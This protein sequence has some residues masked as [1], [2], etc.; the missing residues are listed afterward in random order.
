MALKPN[1][2]AI[3]QGYVD[4]CNAVLTRGGS[5]TSGAPIGD[6]SKSI[7]AIPHDQTLTYHT[8]VGTKKQVT[9]P[10]SVEKYALVDKVG[11]MTYKSYNLVTYPYFDDAIPKTV[12]E[13]IT[14]SGLT[15]TL[16][17]D[18]S[19][20]INGTCNEWY[21]LLFVPQDVV[22]SNGIAI[23]LGSNLP[24]GSQITYE[25]LMDA[26]NDIWDT[27]YL[28]TNGQYLYKGSLTTYGYGIYIE[29]DTIFNN[30]TLR[31][32]IAD[33]TSILP[34]SDYFVG[35]RATKVTD[36]ESDGANYFDKSKV[37][38]ATVTDTGFSFTNTTNESHPY[39]IGVLKDLAPDLKV[40]DVVTFYS[41]V[42]N[43]QKTSYA[44]GFLYIT[45]ASK[46]WYGG[47]FITITEA[48]L[49]GKVY[50]YGKL[51]EV[52][53][54]KNLIITKSVGATYKPYVGKLDTLTMPEYV[55]NIDGYGDGVS[56]EFYNYV[57]F[58]RKKIVVRSYRK[59]CDGTENWGAFST[60][61]EGYYRVLLPTP[62]IPSPVSTPSDK[63]SPIICNHYETLTGN[64]VY[65][66]NRGCLA[67]SSYIGFY[68]PNYNTSDIS[69]WKAHLADLYA[70]GNPLMVVYALAEPIEV[71]ISAYLTDEG[72]IVEGG[73]T[74]TAV[75]EYSQDLPT[76]ITYLINTTGGG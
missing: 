48:H 6:L 61:T 43:P 25:A 41:T 4:A 3:K 19:F 74:I 10:Q 68:D 56:E 51:N 42:I 22:I 75:N 70:Q 53:E 17:A 29:P 20:T 28:G 21:T 12:G 69:L 14:T 26:E 1:A 30:V 65:T 54:Y 44:N 16:N 57:D 52:C 58:K 72:I 66:R 33:S 73:G 47:T 36:L 71:D 35:L 59:V 64:K 34:Y 18:R 45:G 15:I 49:T 38:N 50:A 27:Q 60:N 2:Q 7:L 39:A 11:G 67:S 40:G 63:L 9:V 55:R 5:V 23:S 13:S 62:N 46:N 37:S 24:I 31:P 32:M 76:E 8:G